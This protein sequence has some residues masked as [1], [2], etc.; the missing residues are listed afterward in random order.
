VRGSEIVK[1]YD[2]IDATIWDIHCEMLAGNLTC[3]ALVE[4]YL[5]RI[6]AYDQKGPALNAIIQANPDALSHARE[7]DRRFRASGLT[8]PLHG[9]P[10]L[11]KDN[12]DT[13]GI[14]TT[15]GSVCLLGNIPPQDAFVARKLIAAGALILA[16]VNLHEFAIWGETASS[17]LGQTHNPYDLTR[18]PGGSSGGTGAGIAAGF[19]TIGIGTDTINSIRSPASAN[20]LVG[21]RPTLGLVSRNGIIPYS[22]TQDT[23]GPITL[24]V[25]DAAIVMDVIS[26][27]DPDDTK[28][29]WSIDA[30]PTTY[31]DYLDSNGLSGKR[32]GVLRDFFGTERD[33]QE[34]NATIYQSIEIMRE[35]GAEIIPLTESF[36]SNYLVSDVS[37]HLYDLNDDLNGYLQFLG[38]TAPVHSLDGIIHSGKFH[39]GIEANIRKA[40]TLRKDSSAYQ[41]R[42]IRQ[43][44]LRDQIMKL[45]ADYALDALVYPHQKR[46]VVPIGETQIERNGALASVAGFPAITIPAGFSSPTADAP[47]GVPIGIEFL[48]RPWSEPFLFTIAYGL[49]QA[50]LIR[51]PP[52]STPPVV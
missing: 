5:R 3:Q 37:V 33:H 29:A 23:A 6:A 9:I 42:L 41:E 39:P 51:K 10:V 43:M 35:K 7:L 14:P 38:P 15:G 48:G 18:T 31:L 27:Y 2:V 44:H 11:L 45:F 50:S 16:K 46:L 12:I 20:C 28:T 4:A 13:T 8:G 32:I 40:I 30:K 52:A 21:F 1:D 17:A 24:T 19:G 22:L 49:E 36:D 26:G 25:R 47:I 34:V